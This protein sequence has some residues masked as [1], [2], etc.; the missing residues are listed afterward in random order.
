MET[1]D[2]MYIYRNASKSC[3]QQDMVYGSYKD[4]ARKTAFDKLLLDK[5]FEIASN[6]KYHGYCRALAS[7]LCKS[8]DK[9]CNGSG[10][11]FDIPNQ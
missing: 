3:F 11:V 6:P 5:P 7:I 10:A 4:I 8:F 9:Q 2:S 1:H